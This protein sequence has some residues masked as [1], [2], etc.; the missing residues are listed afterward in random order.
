MARYYNTYRM[1]PAERRARARQIVQ[2]REE[3][4]LFK[5]YL[6]EKEEAER[7]MREQEKQRL[8]EEQREREK[9]NAN[10]IERGLATVGD[11][12]AL[13]GTAGVK[14]I[15]N[16][17]DLG[18]GLIG[19][20]GGI[21][22]DDFED[23]VKEIIAKDWTGTY[24][25]EPLQEALRYSY[26]KDGGIVENIISSV[27]QMLPAVAVSIATQG[28]AI[29]ALVTTMA[30]AAGN[31]TEQAFNDGAEYWRG[32]G[33]GVASGLVE[34]ATEK[35]LGGATSKIFGA[36][37]FDGVVRSVAGEV[38]EQGARRV[39]KDA[40]GEAFEE[41]LAELAN[42]ALK[43]L[44]KGRDAFKEYGE[45]D[46]WKG[47][48]ESA[49]VGGL[50]SV[51]FGGT[52][53]RA[54]K[55]SGVY[56]DVSSALE[57][58]D[59]ILNEVKRL[60]AAGKYS[61][62]AEA[63][64]ARV[65]RANLMNI[66]RALKKSSEAKRA[67]LMDRFHLEAAFEADGSLKESMLKTLEAKENSATSKFK[68]EYY[69]STLRGNEDLIEDDLRA[70]GERAGVETKVFAGELSEK[71]QKNYGK[72]KKALNA[73]NVKSNNN[74]SMV[75]TEANDAYK[76]GLVEDRTMYI[77]ADQLESD[78][79]AGT[80]VHEFTHFE[81]GSREYADMVD[82]LQSDEILVDD[83]KGGKVKLSEKARSTVLAKGYGFTV[84][85]LDAVL[86]KANTDAKLTAEESKIY[87]SYAT[88]LT[89]HETEIVLGNEEFVDRIIAED[90]SAAEKLVSRILKLDKGLASMK[91]K[92][93]RAQAKLIKQAEKLYL[94]AAESAG[95]KRI[96]KMILAQRPELEEEITGINEEKMQVGVQYSLKIKYTDGTVEEIADARNLNNEQV[97]EYLKKAKSGK[98]IGKTYIPVR[99]DTP[100][101]IIDALE[102]VNEKVDN[103]S[104]L[105]QV[106]KAQ[107]AMSK[108][109]PGNRSKKYGDNVR[110]HALTP[111]EIINI[112]NNLDAP[113]AIIYQTN[114]YDKNGKELPNNVVILVDHYDT[115][116]SDDVAVIE[117][118]S[119]ID[120]EF[121][122]EEYGDTE[123]HS[124]ITV[125][126]PDT[127]RNG[128]PFDYVEELLSNPDN[129]ELNIERR[130]SAGSATREI[131]PNTSN[132]LPSD[133]SI[134]H[135]AEKSTENAKKVSQSEKNVQWSLKEKDPLG[136]FFADDNDGGPVYKVSGGKVRKVI[137]DNTR[138]KV[139]SRAESEQI[140]NQ[141]VSENLSFGELYGSLQGKSRREAIDLLW[142]GLN[143]ADVGEQGKVALDVAEYIINNAAVE[144]IH[145][146]EGLEVYTDT[147]ALLKSYLHKMDLSSIKSDIS[148]HYGKDSSPYLLWGKRRGE[149]GLSPDQVAAELSEAGF[150]IDA[151]NPAD[152]FVQINDA[153]KK[154]SSHLKKEAKATLNAGLTAEE[155][156]KLKQDI[157]REVLMA[158]EKG[159]SPSK[160]AG[161]VDRYIKEAKVWREKY[162]AEKHRNETINR[163]LN[164][165]KK[166]KDLKTD[167]FLNA[168]EHK[169]HLFK[170]SIESLSRIEVRGNLNKSSTRKIVAD[171]AE[172]YT[173]DNPMLEANNLFDEEIEGM[174][175]VISHG[176]G[177]LS[178]DEVAMLGDVIDY[179]S[180]FVENYNKVYRDGKYVDAKPEAERYIK[181]MRDNERVKVGWFG[182][183]AGSTYLKT[184]GDPM[185]VMRRLDMYERG[186]YTEMMEQLREGAVGASVMEME[187]R[188]PLEEFYEK[189]KKFL[190]TIRERKVNYGGFEMTASQ[191]ML[192]YMTLNR[193]QALAGLAKSG[194]AY[195]DDKNKT[196][197]VPGF[198]NGE[199]QYTS[200]K[201]NEDI[202]SLVE[203][204]ESG[205][206]DPKE[207]VSLGDVSPEIS[208]EIK[209]ITGIDTTGFKVAI[210]AR[211][212]DHILKDHG[213][214]GKT[215][216]TMSNYSDIAKIE[217]TLN[218]YDEISKGKYTQAY[219]NIVD[220][221]TKGAQTVLYE[222]S[223]GE[224]SY[225]V[226]QAVP[227]TKAKTLFI[228]SAF[229]GPKNIKKEASQFA[230]EIN[231]G[232][233]SEIGTVNTSNNSISQSAEKST[234][235]AKK[236]ADED[237]FTLESLD[238]YAKTEQAKLYDQFT[239]AEKQFISIAER[240]FN[241]DCKNAKREV[242]MKRKGFSNALED[243]YV[244]IRRGN[245]AKSVDAGTFFDE[246]NRASNASFN[247]DTVRGAKNELFIESLDSV[248]DRHIRGVS[249]Y[250]NLAL[251]IDQYDTIFNLA[252]NDNPNK[253][254]TVRTVSENVWRDGAEYFK[255]MI[256][257]IQGIPVESR[258][259]GSKFIRQLR[260]GHAKFQLGANP[261]TWVTQLSSFAA[262]GSILDIDCISRGLGIDA[263]DV[264]EYCSLAKLRNSEN[265]VAM[266]QGLFDEHSKPGKVLEATGKLG[267]LLMVPIGKVDRFV[268][269]RLFGAC[270]AQIEKNGG[271]KVG[272]KAN[273]QAAGEL[274]Q[275]VILETQQN[276]TATDRSAAMRSGNELMK[277]ITMFTADS[278]KVMGRV[279]DSVGEVSVLKARLREAVGQERAELEKRL[280][281]AEKQAARSI[282]SLVTSAVFMAVVAQMFRTLYN[283]DDEDENIAAN[284]AVDAAGNLIGGLP[285]FKEIAAFFM[286]G[287]GLD[288]Y[289]YSALNDLLESAGDIFDIIGAVASGELEGRELAAA[290]KKMAY[291]AGQVLGLPTR[292]AYNVVYGLIKRVNPSAAYSIDD[293]FYKQSYRADLARA[294]EKG[295]DD[296]IATIA[297]LM[298]DENIGGIEDSKSRQELDRLISAGFD[299]IP[300]GVAD[301]ITYDGE[302]YVLGASEKQEFKKIYYVANE[303]LADLVKMQKYKSASD[304]VK[305]AAINYIYKVYWDLALQELVDE[306]LE[307]KTVLFA[308]AIPIEKLALIVA[309][310]STLKADTDKSGK[311]IGGSRK[312]KVQE[313]VNSLDL[314]AVE[315]YMIMGYLGYKNAKGEAAVKAYINKLRLTK[316]EREKLIGYSGY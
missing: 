85:Q 176:K 244:P 21:F 45:A 197:R 255:N 222:K 277:T 236:I 64:T 7:L 170:G 156:K 196:V 306:D 303:V 153:Y 121:I 24:I 54:M 43:S 104:L 313:Y 142:N 233:T 214:N 168:S 272:T 307:T 235:N 202:I 114:R 66:E 144:S 226:V 37:I 249:Q 46:Y 136:D 91:D 138:M 17:A 106:K 266:A 172:W 251:V 216:K 2:Y 225:Y 108:E 133:N 270:Q 167:A 169:P 185:T 3:R 242:D 300:R 36:G 190:Q 273:K 102:Q 5:R 283:K 205:T 315:K 40:A 118:D 160:F 139:Y 26:L 99:K 78:D 204:V 162:Y 265:T 257:D 174:L 237:V 67:E 305:A 137:A 97:V 131:H 23:D 148:H 95:N 228:V 231:L 140:V 50:S 20:I 194:F 279:I 94:K 19:G 262:A 229:I 295:D 72:M 90:G 51:A 89:A 113:Q 87:E 119:S 58:N 292:N 1:T 73:L 146:G 182:K 111:K 166:L 175:Y 55:T 124:V 81:E 311:S 186:F 188:E 232:V 178:T 263:K 82:F 171:L 293:M 60:E 213:K 296:M 57:A 173:R 247:K 287:Y 145:D 152:I 25:G 92:Q 239:D 149:V 134:S 248:L 157:S 212:I 181:I 110:K 147:V 183:V 16:I 227:D 250:A 164:K 122:G 199:H 129:I 223:I 301:S 74:L 42:P 177:Q 47:V 79:W 210:E 184:F 98:L 101:V 154:A 252:V 260:S 31:S 264:D 314:K 294:I 302:E 105:M 191:A 120:S 127:E 11:L 284:M 107:Q 312:K 238:P 100:Q 143:S 59:S 44:Y 253:P 240:I 206:Y 187:I 125:F 112:I 246:M 218:N 163:V 217:Y 208:K 35:L 70:I 80:L 219:K 28:A 254:E 151:E 86:A 289:A 243:Y 9:Q 267:D 4:S 276:A 198:L 189:H 271:A 75:I 109:H 201:T 288:N 68:R 62:E 203:K 180:H 14:G 310:A 48:G 155:R 65:E 245:I 77:P 41:A 316:S 30:G 192:Y 275:K 29:P 261:K 220:G 84:E 22:D 69:S 234:E 165:V 71:A 256:S 211:Q 309:T 179:F 274:L 115:N 10:F 126:K 298:L 224:K 278:M 297:G 141:I 215:D 135:S 53:G 282:S 200:A 304:E 12:F 93:A 123:Y 130:Q 308:E 159:G 285:I 269:K 291:A 128:V 290:M 6:E 299:V 83:D 268:V 52:V 8:A 158:F 49:L 132:K 280:K 230:N 117:F 281:T 195:I 161:I 18:L 221:K 76:G 63:Q 258:R 116:V 38:A 39:I 209:K 96:M 103:R 13:A 150:K 33:Y 241:E 15:E 61:A 27:G 259:D 286:D 32:L 34:G 193:K 56:A 207:K 88:E